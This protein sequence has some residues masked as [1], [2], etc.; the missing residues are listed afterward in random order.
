MCSM[1]WSWA[2]PPQIHSL[3][4]SYCYRGLSLKLCF[5]GS[6]SS[7]FWPGVAHKR[8]WQEMRSWKEGR[9]QASALTPSQSW[10]ASPSVALSSPWLQLL[11]DRSIMIVVC[12]MS[13]PGL[14]TLLVDVFS[15]PLQSQ[16]SSDLLPLLISGLLHCPL[17]SPAKTILSVL[18]PGNGVCFSI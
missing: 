5:R 4:C 18:K 3:N 13:P 10:V 2:S 9:S 15:L 11:S 14:W 12:T 6:E 16:R 17:P 1:G 8:Y 7:G